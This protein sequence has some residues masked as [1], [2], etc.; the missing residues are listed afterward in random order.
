MNRHSFKRLELCLAC[1]FLGLFLLASC[2]TENVPNSEKSLSEVS[3]Q[4]RSVIGFVMPKDFFASTDSTPIPIIS[5]LEDIES[6]HPF[7]ESFQEE[8]GMPLWDYSFLLAGEDTCCFIPLYKETDSLQI[9]SLWSFHIHEGKM[10]Y[11]PIVRSKPSETI[12]TERMFLFDLLSYL[13]FG[14]NNALG[15]TFVNESEMESRAWVTISNCWHVY[16]GTEST[17]LTYSYTNCIDKTYWIDETSEQTLLPE[18]GGGNGIPIGGGAGG[19]TSNAS[20]AKAIFNGPSMDDTL[21]TIVE[22]LIEEINLD[23]LGEALYNGIKEM[24]SDNSKLTLRIIDNNDSNYHWDSNTLYLNVEQLSSEVMLHELMH[25]YQYLN[26]MPDFFTNS[27][28][29][30]EIEAH[31]AQF[32]Y[33][34]KGNKSK[35][36]KFLNSKRGGAVAGI[37]DYIKQLEYNNN[38]YEILNA[39]VDFNVTSE[40]RKVDPYQNYPFIDEQGYYST[41]YNV[42]NL[43][44]NCNL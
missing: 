23:C 22:N 30:Q 29:N 3:S 28:L 38:I 20:K 4:S 31:Y 41:L 15:L 33:L 10:T 14:E 19:T 8:Y 21:W 37:F 40:F 9:N 32:L 34:K 18:E 12:D 42:I 6:K 7:K 13:T 2:N 44:K 25:A 16:T 11:T 5:T 36:R 24:L 39:F 1:K 27:L 43:T 17:G 35:Y 26:T